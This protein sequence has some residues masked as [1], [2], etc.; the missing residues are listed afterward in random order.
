MRTRDVLEVSAVCLLVLA[1]GFG[2]WVCYMLY[3]PTI[4][5]DGKI[6]KDMAVSFIVLCS[7]A[8]ILGTLSLFDNDTAREGKRIFIRQF[9]MCPMA[10]LNLVLLLLIWLGLMD[11]PKVL[12]GLL[13]GGCVGCLIFVALLLASAPEQSKQGG[14]ESDSVTRVFRPC[15]LED[16]KIGVCPGC[17]GEFVPGV[18]I[19]ELGNSTLYHKDCFANYVRCALSGKRSN[20][21]GSSGKKSHA[22]MGSRGSS[23]AGQRFASVVKAAAKRVSKKV[24]IVEDVERVPTE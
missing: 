11:D 23:N 18:L 9:V 4:S 7:F 14:G 2:I 22:S 5:N 10:L 8:V 19:V 17:A 3:G 1:N 6:W 21:S 20:S 24:S 12:V 13:I 16:G 15:L